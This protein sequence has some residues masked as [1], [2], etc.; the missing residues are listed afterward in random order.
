MPYK[1]FVIDGASEIILITSKLNILKIID[2][3]ISKIYEHSLVDERCVV[4]RHRYHMAANIG[5]LLIRTM[6]RFVPH[7]GYLN[8][9][10][11][12]VNIN[13]ALLFILVHVY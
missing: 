7:S 11:D 6:A 2:N 3:R 9:I 13:H 8:F 5:D 1:N 4:D 12:K 10:T